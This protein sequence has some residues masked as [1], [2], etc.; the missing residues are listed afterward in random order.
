MVPNTISPWQEGVCSPAAKTRG[1]IFGSL[2]CAA[3]T[4]LLLGSLMIFAPSQ[5]NAQT[6]FGKRWNP[7]NIY[8]EAEPLTTTQIR[9]TWFMSNQNRE[10]TDVRIYRAKPLTPQNFEFLDCVKSTAV[11]YVDATAKPN[12][13]YSYQIQYQYKRPTML[14]G[15]SNKVTVTSM[16]PNNENSVPTNPNIPRFTSQDP[17]VRSAVKTLMAKAVASNKI[18]LRWGSPRMTKVASLRIFRTEPENPTEFVMIDV[19]AANK[20]SWLDESVAPKKTYSYMLRYNIGTGAILSPPTNIA[21]VT[22]P[23]GPGPTKKARFLSNVLPTNTNTATTNIQGKPVFL[24]PAYY[25]PYS[26]GNSAIPLDEAEAQFL[27]YLNAY[28]AENGVGPVRP[29]INLT[30]GADAYAKDMA[31]RRQVDRIDSQG[32]N[33][34]ARAR[35]WGYNVDTLFGTVAFTSR[36]RP[37]TILEALKYYPVDIAV[38]LDPNWKTL[39]IAHAYDEAGT[40]YWALDFS[41][42]WDY[43][44]PLPGE[45]EDGRIDGNELVRTRPPKAAIEEGHIISGYGDDGKPYSQ[46]HCDTTTKACWKDPAVEGNLALDDGSDPDFMIGVWHIEHTITP[47]GIKHT[48]DPNGYDLTE[49]NMNLQINKDGTWVS[50][51][52]KS[53]QKPVPVEAG[54][55][56]SVHDISANEE[57]VTFYRD[58]GLP[59]ARLRVL[60]TKDTLTFFVV[61]GGAETQNFF[62]SPIY[63][64]IR[65]DDPQVIFKPGLAF[66]LGTS[67]LFPVG[68]RCASCPR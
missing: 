20:S 52:Y 48:N 51:G 50:Q 2:M 11:T 57:I 14:S 29:S 60:A 44:I 7:E 38:L 43:T 31:S 62:K 68:K 12:S 64:N 67:D 66:V 28:R 9:L 34:R 55:W 32:Q 25:N 63:D 54:T 37:D 36:S 27:G 46:L 40:Y 42:F 17:N 39:G 53:Y 24:L 1:G 21:T 22:T 10:Y 56:K 18:E 26:S 35:A 4:V 30:R 8:L 23:D 3:L 5:A 13:T 19:V 33:T 58:N 47:T 45:D 15:P 41:A 65:K 49:F 61:D 6:G 59:A 16:D